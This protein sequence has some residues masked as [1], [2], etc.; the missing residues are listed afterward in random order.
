MMVVTRS[1][2]NVTYQVGRWFNKEDEDIYSN[3]RWVALKKWGVGS[4]RPRAMGPRAV[5]TVSF[6]RGA[7]PKI[8]WAGVEFA[9]QGKLRK[10]IVF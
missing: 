10:L 1:I 5:H 3:G 6:P 7:D 9:T 4:P 8:L 2:N